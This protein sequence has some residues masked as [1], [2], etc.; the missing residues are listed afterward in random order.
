M[1]I[2]SMI[3][4]IIFD[5]SSNDFATVLGFVDSVLPES[6][7]WLTVKKRY[8]EAKKIYERAALLNNREIPPHLLLIPVGDPPECLSVG[9]SSPSC[10]SPEDASP[11][12]S[13]WHIFKTTCLL[14]RLLILFC[15]W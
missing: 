10:N 12:I 9:A 7:R 3:D 8:A 15:T 1:A 6:T 5:R 14:R 2:R 4:R 13:I 11:W